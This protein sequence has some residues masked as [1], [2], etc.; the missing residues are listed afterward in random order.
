MVANT[1][2]PRREIGS[3]SRRSAQPIQPPP[4]SSRRVA[5]GRLAIIVTILGWIAYLITWLADNFFNG[6]PIN[7]RR[8][9]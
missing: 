8:E 5:A 4:V 3:D 1:Q 7:T 6:Q 9:V 2:K